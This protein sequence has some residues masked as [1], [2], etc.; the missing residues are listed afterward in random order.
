MRASVLG[1]NMTSTGIKKKAVLSN[2]IYLNCVRGSELDKS[3]AKALMYEISQE[4]VSPFPLVINNCIRINDNTIS[5]PSG[6]DRYI[7]EGYEII[8]KRALPKVVIPTPGFEPREGQQDA[9]DTFDN[10][11]LVEAPVGYGKTIVGL[12]LAHKFQTR[13]LIITTTTTIRDMW[14][15]EIRKWFGFEPG[16][17]GSGKYNIK[18][19]IVV[20]NIQTVRN[21]HMEISGEFGLL[22]IDEVHR[23][24]S[25][26]FTETLNSSR[27]THKIGLSGTMLRKDGLHCVLPDYFGTSRFV[28]EVENVME[29]TAH[30]YDSGIALN[31]NEFIPWANKITE[32]YANE[33]YRA[34][35][36]TLCN[37]YADAGHIVLFL[38]D[39]TELLEYLHEET[40]ER[41]LIITGKIVGEDRDK[42]MTAM[43]DRKA[44][45]L[46]A[47]QSIFSEGVSI[48]ELSCVILAAPINNL[49]LH[50]QICGRILRLAE[51]KL[52]PVI[53]DIGLE[54]NTGKR[55]RNTRNGL[56]I[57]RG[58][59]MKR[60][61]KI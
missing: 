39:R 53:V 46:F 48:N 57:S 32:L 1:D 40:K 47:T 41:S 55:H 13:T 36:L 52:N 3:I 10:C 43:E 29:P 51:G 17:I 38:C 34:Q 12:G 19:P 35:L 11:G 54:G 28:G 61:G 20:G 25:K 26:T 60:M 56:Y 45:I 15:K 59:S 31:G 8:D 30:L 14:V 49:P 6:A 27:A 2:R 5:I 24:P 33:K 42:I 23:S 21:R 58:W 18:P 4:P 37:V 9:I 16:I 50:T 22:I 44:S 7:P